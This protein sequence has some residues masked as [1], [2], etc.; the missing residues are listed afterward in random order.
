MSEIRDLHE[1]LI[2]WLKAEGILYRRSRS[3]RQSSEACGE[4]DFLIMENGRVLPIE[5]KVKTGKL[6]TAQV[7]RHAEY[8]R[9]NC[10]VFVCR[11]LESA[12]RLVSEWR[13]QTSA[14]APTGRPRRMLHGVLCEEV[15]PGQFQKVRP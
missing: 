13:T 2:A 5:L 6:S 8:A 3:V 1:P 9:A 15:A 11:E 12:C 14:D 7:F 4:P 10:R